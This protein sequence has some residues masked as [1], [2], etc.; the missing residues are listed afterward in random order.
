MGKTLH[1]GK[2]SVEEQSG[3]RNVIKAASQ[4][5]LRDL[6]YYKILLIILKNYLLITKLRGVINK[7][8]FFT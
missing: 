1:K 2:T 5:Y 8:K 3:Q 4:R 6:Y 7:V